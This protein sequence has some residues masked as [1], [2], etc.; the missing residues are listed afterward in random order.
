MDPL[1]ISSGIAGLLSLAI[2]IAQVSFEY[3]SCVKDAPKAI[4]GLIREVACLEEV[5][6]SIRNELLLEPEIVR[7]RAQRMEDRWS[8]R[9]AL[10]QD[11]EKDLHALLQELQNKVKA[12]KIKILDRAVWYF[13]EA[14]ITHQIGLLCR[15]RD[16]FTALTSQD[17]LAVGM[18]TLKEVRAWREEES[19]KKILCWL[20]PLDFAARHQDISSKRQRE[21]L[22]WVLA[23]AEYRTWSR[24]DV[25]L[26]NDNTVLWCYGDPGAGKTY[27]RLV[28]KGISPLHCLIVNVKFASYR[29]FVRNLKIQQAW[30]RLRVLRL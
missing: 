27:A 7:L 10:L 29:S 3:I 16:Q 28:I 11:C 22:R 19:N 17:T 8:G 25:P 18:L 26:M 9:D 15:Y 6:R 12:K 4:K 24:S 23:S 5:L 2:S 1:S 13:N 14:E 30:D 21:T 20:S